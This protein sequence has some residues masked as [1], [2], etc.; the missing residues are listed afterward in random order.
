MTAEM[1][2]VVREER[3]F[4]IG[5]D[6]FR[7]V[8]TRLSTGRYRAECFDMDISLGDRIHITEHASYQAASKAVNAV[9][10]KPARM[11][12]DERRPG[13]AA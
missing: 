2:H 1:S 9:E 3:V 5:D 6:H 7:T 4:R 12:R 8:I 11:S 13:V 10:L